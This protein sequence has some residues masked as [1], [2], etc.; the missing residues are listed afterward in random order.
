MTWDE[1]RPDERDALVAEKVMGMDLT[2]REH[3]WSESMFMDGFPYCETRHCGACMETLWVCGCDD[4]PPAKCVP[5]VRPYS[6]NIVAAWEVFE[7]AL[8]GY[9][10]GQEGDEWRVIGDL[11]Q[12]HDV[13]A[14][15]DTASLVIC[16]AALKEVGA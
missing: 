12:P 1:M 11:Y 15:A 14:R 13:F 2:P 9:Y 4:D 5:Y 3:E 8:D 16:L 7:T 10:I 6:T